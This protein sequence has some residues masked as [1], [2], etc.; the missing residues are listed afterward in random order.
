MKQ[1][2]VEPV[3]HDVFFRQHRHVWRKSTTLTDVLVNGTVT[4][5]TRVMRKWLPLV[6]I[7]LGTFMLLIDVTIVNV[8]LPDMAI[9]L[10][11]SFT[12]LQWVIDIY[13]LALAALLLGV[14]GFADLVGRKRVYIGGLLLFAASS[15][16]AGLSTSTTMLIT[17]R[18]VQGVGAAAMFATTIALINTSYHGRDRGLA[19]GVWGAFNGAAAAAGPILGGL[20]TQGLSWRWIFFVNL[21]ITVIAVFLGLRVLTH[22]ER[23]SGARID[24]PG[25]TAFTIAAGSV[26]FALTRA[27]ENGWGSAMTIGF[28]ALG[29][30]ALVA[31]LV[32]EAHVRAPILEPALLRRPS[33]SGILVGAMLLPI[34]AF[35]ALTYASL[36]LQSVNGMS[37]IQTGLALVPLALTALPVSLIGGRFLHNVSPRWMISGGLTFIGLGSLAQ[38]HLGGGSSWSALLPGLVLIGI[39]VGLATPILA[40]AALA[41]VPMERGG[42]ASGAVNTARQLGY[43]LGIAGL[44]VICQSRIG[45][46]ISDVPGLVHGSVSATARAITGG[47]G[48][49][50]LHAAPASAQA[51]V[52]AAIHN[53]Y[54]SGLNVTLIVAGAIGLAGAAWVAVALRPRPAEVEAN[55]EPEPEAVAA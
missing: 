36:W 5:H 54:A 42:M 40:S 29:A 43:A 33:F 14:G 19:F 2:P 45:A 16:T 47:Q 28:L 10:H 41:S 30:A 53:A 44:G 49:A 18:A 25:V 6:T 52:N 4:G 21:P 34:A 48:P 1:L 51:T 3:Q 39:G 26:T 20:L 27:G 9:D 32:I 7:S 22:D 11:T 55:A 38:A 31:F 13:A 50:L 12:D 17:A 37:P 35:A 46:L 23:R 15:L 24:L 8:A